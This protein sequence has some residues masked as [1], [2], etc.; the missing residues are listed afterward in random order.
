MAFWRLASDSVSWLMSCSSCSLRPWGGRRGGARRGGGRGAKARQRGGRGGRRTTIGVARAR[1]RGA[2]VGPARCS[3]RLARSDARAREARAAARARAREGGAGAHLE[4]LRRERRELLALLLR[5]RASS[6]AIVLRPTELTSKTA[7]RQ[8]PVS[9]F[10][11]FFT[12][13]SVSTFD[14]FPFQ[15]TDGTTLDWRARSRSASRHR[16][17]GSAPNVLNA[18]DKVR[19]RALAPAPRRARRE[20]TPV[21]PRLASL[22]LVLVVF[23]APSRRVA[24]ALARLPPPPPADADADAG[25]LAWLSLGDV[26]TT[27][28]VCEGSF[29]ASLNANAAACDVVTGSLLVSARLPRA[30][31]DARLARVDGDVLVRDNAVEDVASR[32]VPGADA[33]GRRRRRRQH[34][35]SCTSPSF[36]RSRRWAAGCSS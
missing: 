15:L 23:A 35:G 24:L 33:R 19:R 5:H 29:D 4:L 36:P 1:D 25:R 6:R 22:I 11:T 7:A 20:S 16:Q 28:N 30:F 32:R 14:R 2:D 8:R 31:D 18:E 34:A 26:P 13:H 27:P 3:F 9:A 21:M 17:P 10:K 12:H